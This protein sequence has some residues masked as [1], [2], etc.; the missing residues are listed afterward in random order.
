LRIPSASVEPAQGKPARVELKG[1]GVSPGIAVGPALVMEREAVPGLR[2]LLPAD[3]VEPEVQRLRD[4]VATSQRQLLEIKDR[5]SQELGGAPARILDAQLLM[6]EDALLME[7][8][9]SVIRGQSVNAEW[10]LRTV[11]EQLH[12]LFDALTDA[13]LRER[14]TDLDDVLGRVRLNLAGGVDAPSLSHLPGPHVLVA[15]DLTPSE[16][17]ELD[18]D[19]VLGLAIDAG[20]R[21]Y[22][23][24]ILAR[25]LGLPTVVGLG[26]ACRRIPP[27]AVVVVD[28]G[29]GVVVVAPSSLALDGYRVVQQREQHEDQ[30]M[31][32]TRKL[33][34]VTPD[35]VRVRLL[36]NVEFPDEAAKAPLYGAE[37]IG[38]FRS[39]YLLSRSRDWPDEEEQLLVYRGLLERMAPHPVTVRLWDLGPEDLGAVVPAS[40]NPALGQRAFRLLERA[41]DRFRAQLRALLRA[42]SH[43]PLRIMFP[44][45]GGPSDLREALGFLHDVREGLRSEGAELGEDVL[46]GVNIEVPSAALTADLLAPDVDFFSVG[47]NDLIQYTLAVD[48]V[49]PRTSSLYESLHPA[50]LRTLRMITQAAQGHG[51]EVSVCGEM[52]ADPLHALMLLGLGVRE[53]S[54]SPSAIP[55]VKAA[56]RATPFERA[57]AVAEGCLSLP[58]AAEIEATLR[59]ELAPHAVTSSS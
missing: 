41:P 51:V 10:A 27:G 37:G 14:F 31:R 45:L 47:T 4:A 56:V 49:D 3:Q 11:S 54:M 18:W 55:R 34:A 15:A 50:I 38:L 8:S 9:L 30:K 40:P 33:P 36:A 53:L 20:S 46:V 1:T 13:Y 57:R 5:L 19:S 32:A 26:D 2:R 42:A 12:E 16:A 59:R 29:A 24:A 44:F 6:L 39:E 35:G 17:A 7:R 48:R 58:T 25:S 22:H 23:T 28:G 52:A 43:G 21:T